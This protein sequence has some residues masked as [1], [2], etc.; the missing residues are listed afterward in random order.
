MKLVRYSALALSAG[1]AAAGYLI[2]QLISPYEAFQKEIFVEGPRGASAAQIAERLLNA[3]VIRNE[4]SFR[5]ARVVHR[6]R[7]LQAG[8]YR[9]RQPAAVIDVYDRIARGDVF[10]V[11]LAVPEGKNIFDIAAL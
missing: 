10:F 7:G 8:E 4:W 9:F 2:Y 3:G 11:E 5:V 1:L 6:G